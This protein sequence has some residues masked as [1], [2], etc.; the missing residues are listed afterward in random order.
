MSIFSDH[1]CGALD[2]YEFAQECRRMN[3]QDRYERE[4][5][6]EIDEE[7]AEEEKNKIAME[8]TKAYAMEREFQ[9]YKETAIRAFLGSAENRARHL[10]FQGYERG[11]KARRDNSGTW[12]PCEESEPI[13]QREVMV[14][15]RLLMWSPQAKDRRWSRPFIDII[16]WM[17][18]GR[19]WDVCAIADR[20]GFKVE[21]IKITA[22][23]EIPNAYQEGENV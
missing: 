7:E 2:D 15:Y 12:I 22:W 8:K 10:F 16:E 6:D 14:T 17:D 23:R 9:E 13:T 18:E 20:T 3:A 19:G 11:W 1:E 21:E 5:L 4:R